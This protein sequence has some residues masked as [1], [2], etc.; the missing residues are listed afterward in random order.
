MIFTF[1]HAGWEGSGHDGRVLN[2]A[3]TKGFTIRPGKFW[4]ADAGYSLTNTIPR[5]SIPFERMEKG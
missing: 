1:I 3:L 5:C 2:H 4:L